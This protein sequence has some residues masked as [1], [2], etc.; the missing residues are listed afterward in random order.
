MIQEI[1]HRSVHVLPPIRHQKM[2]VSKF[3]HNK[4]PIPQTKI[5]FSMWRVVEKRR[6]NYSQVEEVMT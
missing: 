2:V 4:K 6:K 1:P 3:N 5:L